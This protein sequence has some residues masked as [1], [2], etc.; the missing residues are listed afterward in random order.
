M[1]DEF[2]IN[3]K[4]EYDDEGRW[5][6]IYKCFR[7]YGGQIERFFINDDDLIYYENFSNFR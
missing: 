4:K 6:E 1:S 5:Q 3:I 2:K 7:L